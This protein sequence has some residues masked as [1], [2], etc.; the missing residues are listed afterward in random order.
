MAPAKLRVQGKFRR[1][2]ENALTD[3]V[4]VRLTEREN[5]ELREAAA[6]AEITLSE[7]VKR[8]ALGRVVTASTDLKVVRELRRL[9][10]LVKHVATMQI[11][12]RKA[13]NETLNA[14]G[15]YVS[16]LADDRQVNPESRRNS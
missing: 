1:H 14:L 3:R 5:A 13:I 8:R 16:V 4:N 11:A 15:H 9:G 6:A 12:D 10:G 7:Y 2:G